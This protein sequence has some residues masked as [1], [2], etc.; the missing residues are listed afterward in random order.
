MRHAGEWWA[1][2]GWGVRSPSSHLSRCKLS[3]Y[4]AMHVC[5]YLCVARH[6]QPDT[7][8]Y[9]LPAL[10]C[11]FNMCIYKSIV[12]NPLHTRFPLSFSPVQVCKNPNM[13]SS[14]NLV[15]RLNGKYFTWMA[16]CP[17]VMTMITFQKPL[18]EVS[19]RAKPSKDSLLIPASIRPPCAGGYRAT[20]VAKSTQC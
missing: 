10:H 11:T 14:P 17:I 12:C 7:L 15:V 8:R 13:F 5:V 18:T 16:A 19:L 4:I 2:N 1:T 6:W 3:I 20:N 9:K